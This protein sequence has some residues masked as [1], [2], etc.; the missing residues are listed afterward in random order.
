MLGTPPRSLLRRGKVFVLRTPPGSLPVASGSV[1]RACGARRLL[2]FA[3]AEG[4]AQ[5]S[6]CV[7]AG[8]FE[9]ELC[10]CMGCV[11]AGFLGLAGVVFAGFP[12]SWNAGKG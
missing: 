1:L 10:G 5:Q 4:S 6:M 8:V 2:I 12:A 11:V 9:H 7:F 3:L